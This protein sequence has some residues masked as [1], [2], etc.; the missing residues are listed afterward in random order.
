VD[1]PGEQPVVD[2]LGQGVSGVQGLVHRQWGL[3]LQVEIHF[4]HSTECRG[5]SLKF[6]VQV[7][8]FST[9]VILIAFVKPDSGSRVKNLVQ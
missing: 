2:A 6:W 5:I 9:N 3:Q 8:G 7:A 4:V 1:D